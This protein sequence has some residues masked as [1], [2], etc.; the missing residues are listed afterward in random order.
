MIKL[1]NVDLGVRKIQ[2]PV[3]ELVGKQPGKTLLITA[4]MDGDEYVGIEAAY[5]LIEKYTHA[6]FSGTLIVIPI[7]NVPAFKAR[8]SANPLDGKFPKWVYPGSKSGTPTERLMWWLNDYVLRSDIWL[9]LHGGAMH[10]VL[11]PYLYFYETKDVALKKL[12]PYINA[13][14]APKIVIEKPGSFKKTELLGKRGIIYIWTEAGCSGQRDKNSITVHLEWVQA[15]M[16]VMR[17]IKFSK[18][19]KKT[20]RVYRNYRDYYTREGGFW[21]PRVYPGSRVSKGLLIGEVRNFDGSIKEKHSALED[22]ELLWGVESMNVNKG[23]N[24]FALAT[25]LQS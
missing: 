14:S 21:Y 8:I 3:A 12:T 2:V 15:V 17:M 10:E 5:R 25:E 9:D 20:S 7:V 18:K 22:G 4:G 16:G 13:L 1:I 11:E 6:Y 19:I 23:E 24:I